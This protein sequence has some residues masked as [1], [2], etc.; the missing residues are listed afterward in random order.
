MGLWVCLVALLLACPSLSSIFKSFFIPLSIWFCL[1]CS[2]VTFPSAPPTDATFPFYSPALC[3][4]RAL[5]GC[6][7][8]PEENWHTTTEVINNV[9]F[10]PCSFP[11]LHGAWLSWLQ[12][13]PC[14][15]SPRQWDTSS[16][17][18]RSFQRY[19]HLKNGNECVFSFVVNQLLY[20]ILSCPYGKLLLWMYSLHTIW[21]HCTKRRSES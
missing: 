8:L 3:S 2:T 19:L 18:S 1:F 11:S 4:L 16:L 20:E 12:N 10:F 9:G 14:L 7:A 13:S 21:T 5:P 17:F 15:I 6:T